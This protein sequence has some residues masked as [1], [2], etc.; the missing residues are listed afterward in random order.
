MLRGLE[1]SGPRHAIRTHH[2]I[3]YAMGVRER[4]LN[5]VASFRG[6]TE[7]QIIENRVSWERQSGSEKGGRQSDTSP[8]HQYTWVRVEALACPK[9]VIMHVHENTK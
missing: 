5:C 1:S 7:R 9:L 3:R 2:E 8:Y 6:S 4:I